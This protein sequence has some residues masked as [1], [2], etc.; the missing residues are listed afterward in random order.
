[1]IKYNIN[2]ELY[3]YQ[4]KKIHLYFG[5]SP[6][7]KNVFKLGRTVKSLGNYGLDDSAQHTCYLI[8]YAVLE[9]PSE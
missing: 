6:A 4:K 3:I 1:M 9:I 2:Y 5:G 8:I 7:F